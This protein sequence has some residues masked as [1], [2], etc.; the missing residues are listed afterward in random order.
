MAG[1]RTAGEKSVVLGVGIGDNGNA[2]YFS[3][4]GDDVEVGYGQGD[5]DVPGLR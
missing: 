1:A 2:G 3:Y 5:S 4:I